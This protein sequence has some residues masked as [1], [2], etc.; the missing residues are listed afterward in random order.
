M[1][2]H[3]FIGTQASNLLSGAARDAQP[4]LITRKLRHATVRDSVFTRFCPRRC[5][6]VVE[7]F[8]G[9]QLREDC[10][11]HARHASVQHQILSRDD[12]ARIA[13]VCISSVV[14]TLGKTITNN[15]HKEQRSTLH[16]VGAAK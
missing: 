8:M 16:R 10:M 9:K 6:F 13:L 2:A 3:P 4:I 14:G 5:T 15:R 11:L 7:K 1:S 12:A